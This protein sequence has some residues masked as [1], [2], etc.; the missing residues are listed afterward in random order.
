MGLVQYAKNKIS[1]K[2]VAANPDD[3]CS[4]VSD[5]L[6]ELIRSDRRSKGEKGTKK[7]SLSTYLKAASLIKE[8]Y[9]IAKI[10]LI[11]KNV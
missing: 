5:V 1:I 10:T 2:L 8:N 7:A 3:V 11:K 4:L 9:K 6:Y